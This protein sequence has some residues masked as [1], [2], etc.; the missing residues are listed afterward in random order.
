[1][2]PPLPLLPSFQ[3]D[4]ALMRLAATLMRVPP[5]PM[6]AG[7]DAGKSTCALPSLTPSVAR[8]SPEATNTDTLSALASCKTLFMDWTACCV[9]LDSALPQLIEITEGAFC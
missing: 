1:M 3:T 5:Q 6:A 9:Q 2:P 7:L 8:L 4:S